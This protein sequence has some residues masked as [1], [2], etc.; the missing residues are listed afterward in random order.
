MFFHAWHVGCYYR[1][2]FLLYSAILLLCA[3]LHCDFWFVS[4]REIIPSKTCITVFLICFVWF[5]YERKEQ[6]GMASNRKRVTCTWK[7]GSEKKFQLVV[8]YIIYER[9][10]FSLIY[11]W[12]LDKKNMGLFIYVAYNA[13]AST[14]FLNGFLFVVDN[15]I[16]IYLLFILKESYNHGKGWFKFWFSLL[17]RTCNEIKL[18]DS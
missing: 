10:C 5:R 6:G 18:Q 2:L 4:G 3:I 11:T 8:L 13:K 14:I 15:V 16:V 9:F 12:F 7:K 17:R 1:K